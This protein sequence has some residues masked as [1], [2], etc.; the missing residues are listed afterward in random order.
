MKKTK[1]VTKS[2]NGKEPE[3]QHLAQ[4]A[5]FMERVFKR[6][7][8]LARYKVRN[9]KM[10]LLCYMHKNRYHDRKVLNEYRDWMDKAKE[11]REKLLKIKETH[12]SVYNRV[13]DALK[14]IGIPADFMET[15]QIKFRELRC[16]ALVP[17]YL[18]VLATKS[19]IRWPDVN[20][21]DIRAHTEV[22]L[23]AEDFFETCEAF[24]K[25]VTQVLSTDHQLRGLMHRE[26]PSGVGCDHDRFMRNAL[27]KG[28]NIC[29]PYQGFNPK[30]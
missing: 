3:T 21:G 29:R 13:L 17:P 25:R 8:S 22:L 28:N 2:L 16:D 10:A 7:A 27:L 15:F 9:G 23:D 11:K 14:P 20:E 26:I 4:F 6:P 24:C 5:Y 18:R 30:K 12:P 1:S 19:I